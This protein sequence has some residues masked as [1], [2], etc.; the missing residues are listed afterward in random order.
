VNIIASLEDVI[1]K[2][3]M[4][5]ARLTRR[6]DARPQ[7]ERMV[8]L[9]AVA[10]VAFWL[11]DRLWLT[12]AFQRS[13]AASLHLASAGN[14]LA[15]LRNDVAKLKAMGA[16]QERAL[17]ADMVQARQRAEAGAAALREHESTLISAGH[18]VELLEQMLPAHGRLKVLELRSLDPTDLLAAPRAA[19]AAA[20]ATAAP[21]PGPSVYRQGVELTLEGSYV[22]LLEY[23]QALEKMPRRVLWGGLEMKAEQHPA[24]VLKLRLYT[25]SLDRGWLEI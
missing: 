19:S 4:R 2:L 22:D 24:V 23:L 8:L 21:N 16:Q 5:V 14:D 3:R 13:R 10:A 17:Q 7:R 1:A 6:F 20:S 18:M 12:P 15:T 25:L 11:A 9:I